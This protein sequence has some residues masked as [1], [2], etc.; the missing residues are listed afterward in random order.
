MEDDTAPLGTAFVGARKLRSGA[1][2]LHLNSAAAADWVRAP[3]RIAIFLAGMG[4]T[5]IYRPRSFSV[6]V[7][8]VPVSFDPAL[9]RAL[10]SI[11]DS[12]GLARNELVQARF[13]KPIARR[14]VGQQSAHAIFGFASAVS[15]NRAI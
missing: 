7:E 10:E 11:E 4:G 6:V 3:R 5:S 8:F 9:S 15:A 14:R 2:V 13:I 12:N 1:I